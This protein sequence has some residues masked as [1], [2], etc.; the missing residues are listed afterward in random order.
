LNICFGD[1]LLA[2]MDGSAGQVVSPGS[3]VRL[4]GIFD[5]NAPAT[6]N[7][8]ISYPN[9]FSASNP[10]GSCPA[11]ELVTDWGLVGSLYTWGYS[12]VA[13]VSQ[14]Q[15]QANYNFL[16]H[17]DQSDM[18]NLGIAKGYD[19]Q[20]VIAGVG[21]NWGDDFYYSFG[22]NVGEGQQI[23]PLQTPFPTTPLTGASGGI[24]AVPFP[25]PPKLNDTQQLKCQQPSPYT[26]PYW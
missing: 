25:N 1:N 3:A 6:A 4:V 24:V 20:P 7:L 2:S 16:V 23:A 9:C 22:R 11:A 12:S 13:A 21:V 10:D 19:V 15:L 17:I 26:L 5:L 14:D 8:T 18:E